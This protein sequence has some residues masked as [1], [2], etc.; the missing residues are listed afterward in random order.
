MLQA[1]MS[2]FAR[3]SREEGASATEYAVIVAIVVG[4]LVALGVI[5]GDTL[6]DLWQSMV[7]LITTNFL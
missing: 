4:A 3:P 5:F 1:I 2:R 7:D 6:R